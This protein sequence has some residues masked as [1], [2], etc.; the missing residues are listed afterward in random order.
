MTA[1]LSHFEIEAKM[2]FIKIDNMRFIF[3]VFFSFYLRCYLQQMIQVVIENRFWLDRLA[4][5]EQ[6]ML[7]DDTMLYFLRSTE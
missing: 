3:D 2:L 6:M 5:K 1:D 4:P 7:S